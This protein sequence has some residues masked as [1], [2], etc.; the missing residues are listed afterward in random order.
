MDDIRSHQSKYA[1]TDSAKLES[2]SKRHH[3]KCEENVLGE[4]IHTLLQLR[5]LQARE[6]RV[7]MKALEEV[8]KDLI[9]EQVR[10]MEDTTELEDALARLQAYSYKL[11]QQLELFK[12]KQGAQSDEAC[13]RQEKDGCS[14]KD[15]FVV[16]AVIQKRKR[17]MTAEA[18]NCVPGKKR[19]LNQTRP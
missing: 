19:R 10:R 8:R 16:K 17:G 15:L 9:Q 13:S 11:E 18:C 7:S 2:S 6:T 4:V 3:G 14:K 1:D 12:N 5:T